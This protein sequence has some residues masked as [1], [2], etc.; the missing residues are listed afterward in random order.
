M[1]ILS[2]G[3]IAAEIGADRDRVCYAIRKAGIQPVGR[4]GLVRLFPQSAV[5]TVRGFL[6]AKRAPKNNSQLERTPA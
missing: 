2:T 1:L 4:A 6:A 5:E 3:Q